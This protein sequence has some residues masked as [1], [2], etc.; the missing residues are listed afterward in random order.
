MLAPPSLKNVSHYP[1]T[2]GVAAAALMATGMWWSGQ[3]IDWFVMNQRVWANFELWRALT[4]TLPHANFFHLAFNLYWLWTF[5]TLVERV[6]GH[7][8]C[9]ADI[10]AAGVRFLA[11]GVCIVIRWRG[12]V[13]RGLWLMGHVMGAGEA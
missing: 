3:S 5:G 13:R 6:Y 12:L 4:C 1:V 7:F 10:F 2:A 9:A 8:R 11:R